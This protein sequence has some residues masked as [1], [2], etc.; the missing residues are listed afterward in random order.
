MNTGIQY[1][2]T[3]ETSRGRI[4]GYHQKPDPLKLS[5]SRHRFDV[6]GLKSKEV[7]NIIADSTGFASRFTIGFEVEK[8]ALHRNSVREYELFCGF[9][10]DASCGYEAV[11]HIL[12]LLPAGQWRTKVY[13][14]MHKATHIIDDRFSPSN[15]TCGGHVT[16]GVEGLTGEEI[17]TAVRPYC[18]IVLALFRYR[19]KNRYCGLNTNLRTASES[20]DSWFNANDEMRWASSRYQLA[21]DKGK[22]LEFRVV[23]R[24]ENV[25]QMMRRYELF[26]ALLD[27]ALNTKGRLSSFHKH[28]R[29]IVLSMYGGNETEANDIFE[30]AEHFQKFINTGIIHDSIR[31]FL[32]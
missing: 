23:S 28:I 22:V 17:L 6:S 2:L 13:D 30:K 26:Y 18:G 16:L 7:R 3:G 1:T 10:T 4:V 32:F 25:K 31:K 29:P 14:M 15:K 5:K 9:E 8:T 20:T 11:S 24:Y 19:L 27:F 21:L 12:P